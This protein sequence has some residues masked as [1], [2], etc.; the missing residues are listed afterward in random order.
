MFFSI[1]FKLHII[2]ILSPK[3]FLVTKKRHAAMCHKNPIIEPSKY[4]K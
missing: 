3:T 1:N 2:F 4:S